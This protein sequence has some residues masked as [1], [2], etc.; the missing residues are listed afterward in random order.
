MSALL[1]RKSCQ[2]LLDKLGLSTYYAVINEQYSNICLKIVSVCGKDLFKVENIKFRNGHPAK[3]D[4]L[5]AMELFEEF[6]NTHME[7]IEAYVKATRKLASTPQ[8]VCI[9]TPFRVTKS[10][11]KT[12]P[13]ILVSWFDKNT[14]EKLSYAVPSKLFDYTCNELKLADI[15]A[16]VKNKTVRAELVVQAKIAKAFYKAETDVAEALTALTACEI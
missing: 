15:G 14:K 12:K 11:I 2:P 1:L 8:V 10:T 3:G 7:T 16:L 6:I 9:D 13:Q 4:V 5:I